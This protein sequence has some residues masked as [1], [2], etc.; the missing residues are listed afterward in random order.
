MDQLGREIK[1]RAWDRFKMGFRN[2]FKN[3][4]DEKTFVILSSLTLV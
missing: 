1:M 4:Y 3:E 2:K